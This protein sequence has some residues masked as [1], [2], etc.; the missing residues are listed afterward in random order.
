VN[1][2]EMLVRQIG[3]VIQAGRGTFRRVRWEDGQIEG[4]N[5][6]ELAVIGKGQ[7]FEAMVVRGA[8]INQYKRG[9]NFIRMYDVK[10]LGP[11]PTP[12]ECK[13]L[14]DRIMERGGIPTTA[15]LPAV[16][17]DEID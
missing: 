13:A 17:W 4:I 10:E 12:E 16:S 9:W 6:P 3:T 14:W 7:R 5:S 8:W 11:P 15:D 2:K 1:D